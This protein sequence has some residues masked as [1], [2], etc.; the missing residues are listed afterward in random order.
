MVEGGSQ[1]PLC[2]DLLAFS[3]HC[4]HRTRLGCTVGLPVSLNLFASALP[5]L[6]SVRSGSNS[7]S[8]HSSAHP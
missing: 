6:H 3:A 1:N 4:A 8:G 2:F 7:C 5:V